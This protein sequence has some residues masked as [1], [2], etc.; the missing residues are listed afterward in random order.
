MSSPR[1]I[2]NEGPSSVQN[3]GKVLSPSPRVIPNIPPR[4]SFSSSQR[5]NMSLTPHSQSKHPSRD[6]TSAKPTPKASNDSLKKQPI[7][8]PNGAQSSALTASMASPNQ[9]QG[10]PIPDPEIPSIPSPAAFD[11]TGTHARSPGSGATTPKG[12]PDESGWSS[13]AEIPDERKAAVLRRHLVSA[14]EREQSKTGT[15]TATSPGELSPV[16]VGE[17]GPSKAAGESAVTYGSTSEN[18][19]QVDDSFPIPYDALGGDVT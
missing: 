2:E 19:S 6:R 9:H 17:G 8:P 14:E 4:A 5:P 1:S 15:P 16:K 12:G 13:L 7:S 11:A 3:P 10:L 18:P